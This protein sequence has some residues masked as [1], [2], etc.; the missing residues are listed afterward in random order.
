MHGAGLHAAVPQPCQI[1]SRK[2]EPRRVFHP[3]GVAERANLQHGLAS[4]ESDDVLELVDVEGR[5]HLQ[6]DDSRS[7]DLPPVGYWKRTR[8]RAPAIDFAEIQCA[9]PETAHKGLCGDRF[10]GR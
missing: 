1:V 10:L 5:R 3:R 7:G 6:L 8:Q 9:E 2:G 4:L